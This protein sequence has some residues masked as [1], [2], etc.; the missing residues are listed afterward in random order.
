ME[1]VFALLTAVAVAFGPLAMA[2]TKLVDML[3]NLL[4]R[5]PETPWPKWVWNAAAFV[6]ALAV[7]ILWQLDVVSALVA[8]VPAFGDKTLSPVMGQV[9]TG[10][11]VAGFAAFWHEHMDKT[12]HQAKA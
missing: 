3:R 9:L 8:Q 4:D 7:C 12:S 1:D 5:T 6:I 2:V 11:G 10:L